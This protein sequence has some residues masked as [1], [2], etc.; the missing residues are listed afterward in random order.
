MKK[1]IAFIFVLLFCAN[2]F[3]Y[4]QTAENSE[5]R[6][7]FVIVEGPRPEFPGGINALREYMAKNAGI[8]IHIPNPQQRNRRRQRQQQIERTQ[9]P[10]IISF[11][12]ERDGST[13]NVRIFGMSYIDVD[14][15]K[16][17]VHALQE[18]PK[19]TPAEQRGSPVPFGYTIRF[20][21]L[22]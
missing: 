3:C 5:E 14:A 7:V 17:I 4:S 16:R 13:S 12:I 22:P 19:W 11:I 21:L 10:Y 1:H 20:R 15:E 18:M 9:Y 6:V 2:V 8:S